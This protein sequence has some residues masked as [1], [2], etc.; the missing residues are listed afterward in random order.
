[1]DLGSISELLGTEGM[2]DFIA[3]FLSGTLIG[4]SAASIDLT[5]PIP[6]PF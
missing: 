6:G 5:W 3:K 2:I 4:G 1:M